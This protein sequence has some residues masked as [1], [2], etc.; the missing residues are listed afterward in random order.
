[1]RTKKWN[2][3]FFHVAFKYH[4]LGCGLID[5]NM[6]RVWML[7]NERGKG[8][9]E[10][11]RASWPLVFIYLFIFAR[12]YWSWLCCYF[13]LFNWCLFHRVTQFFLFCD[14]HFGRRKAKC[15]WFPPLILVIISYAQR[16]KSSEKQPQKLLTIWQGIQR[17]NEATEKFLGAH[18]V[19]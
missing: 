4:P 9:D 18:E 14:D 12:L 11:R 19:Y 15:H 13:R 8:K 7:I 16:K 2:T 5:R 6:S 3:Y 17:A 1:M 10:R